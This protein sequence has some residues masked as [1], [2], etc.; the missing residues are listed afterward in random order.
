VLGLG[1]GLEL[2]SFILMIDDLFERIARAEQVIRPHI[3][4]TP[5][6]QS[7]A[8]SEVTGA[9]VWLK[10][11]NLQVTGSFKARGATHR[12][13]SLSDDVRRRGV[14]AASSGNHG[15]GVAYAGHTLGIPVT[16]Y[17]PDFVSP[18]KADGMRRLGATVVEFG[19]DGLD[20]ELEARRVADAHGQAYVSPYN[21]WS[22][23]AGQGTVGVELERQLEDIST[24][25]VAVGGGGLI[26]GIGAYLKHHA[27]NVRVVGAQPANSNVMIA[28]MRAG[29]VVEQPSLPTL[30]DGTAGGIEADTVTFSLCRSVVDEWVEIDEASIAE[31]IRH[32]IE[33]EHMLIEGSAGVAIAALSKSGP[34]PSGRVV[35]VLCGANISAARLR[36]AL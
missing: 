22:V 12:L 19:T 1:L 18:A 20:T 21:D 2:D 6:V 36:A 5:V 16:V 30:S 9:D 31:S 3:R 26:G 4:E 33:V 17:V 23:V 28:S 8:L 29:H 10:C 11:E 27:P 25:I 15:V 35:V 34:L 7:L 24:V 13:L 14:V 32:A